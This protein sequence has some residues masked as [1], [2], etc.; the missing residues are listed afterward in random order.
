MAVN[1]FCLFQKPHTYCFAEKI[2]NINIW[3]LL[4]FLILVEHALQNFF[5]RFKNIIIQNN[6]KIF[7]MPPVI[8][9]PSILTEIFQFLM[10]WKRF[11][12]LSFNVYSSSCHSSLSNKQEKYAY[13]KH[14]FSENVQSETIF[15]KL[16]IT[17]TKRERLSLKYPCINVD[18]LSL[19]LIRQY[20]KFVPNT[21]MNPITTGGGVSSN[22]SPPLGFFWIS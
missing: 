17:K 1:H 3:R 2:F 9:V 16:F 21:K 10:L 5:K 7:K 13:R 18:T 22:P 8:F 12:P 6:L 20:I 15:H 19:Y 14:D 4:V 11:A